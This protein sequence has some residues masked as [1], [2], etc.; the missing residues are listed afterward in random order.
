MTISDCVVCLRKQVMWQIVMGEI[1]FVDVHII[2]FLF[3]PEAANVL[4]NTDGGRQMAGLTDRQR[5]PAGA[6]PP[7]HCPP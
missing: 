6:K 4:S 5:E 7:C 2:A 3:G 1:R